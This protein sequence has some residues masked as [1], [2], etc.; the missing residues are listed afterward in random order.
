MAKYTM[1][2]IENHALEKSQPGNRWCFFNTRLQYNT[3]IEKSCQLVRESASHI[4]VLSI[5]PSY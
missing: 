5:I 3:H 2:F 1:W 4:F